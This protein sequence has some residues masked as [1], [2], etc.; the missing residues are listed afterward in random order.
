MSRRIAYLDCS[1]GVA[2]DMLLASL[3][4]AGVPLPDLEGLLGEIGIGTHVALSFSHVTRGAFRASHLQVAVANGAPT[5]SLGALESSLRASSLP[6]EAQ[7]RSLAD[8]ARLLAVEAR[9][10]GVANELHELGS[11]DTIVDVVGFHFACARLGL[12]SLVTSPI[13][14]GGGAVTFAHGTFGVPAPATAE[15]L[16]GVPIHGDDAACGELTTPTG[17]LLVSGPTVTHGPLPPMRIERIGYGAGTRETTRANF[18]RCFVGTRE[19]QG[20]ASRD[21]VLVLE[22]NLDDMNPQLYE[23]LTERLFAL[24]ALDVSLAAVIGKHGRPATVVT[25]IA[26]LGHEHELSGALFEESTTLGVRVSEVDRVVLERRIV[27]VTTSIGPVDVKVS[28]LP[29]GRE[30]R[31]AEHRDVVALA[32]QHGL[33]VVDAARLVAAEIEAENRS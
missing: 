5:W 32:K 19:E 4:D 12:D 15:L 30:R 14:V 7:R 23:T 24:G 6:A 25:V 31:V 16:A 27:R 20:T 17:A 28:R 8:L 2:G 21:R 29:G 3:I 13:N 10:H 22:T 9:L 11:L 26:P 33:T 18:V 1:S